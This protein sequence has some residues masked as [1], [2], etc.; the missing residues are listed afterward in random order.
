MSSEERDREPE[1]NREEGAEEPLEEPLEQPID[2]PGEE[3]PSVVAAPDEN[4]PPDGT[5]PDDVIDASEVEV[6]EE[7]GEPVAEEAAVEVSAEELEATRLE[8]DQYRDDMMYLR[9]EFDNV[10][11]RQ[12]R[13]MERVRLN[14]SES[15]VRELLPVLDNLERALEVEGDVR[16]GVKATLD[17]FAS[18]LGGEGLTPVPSDGHPFDPNIHEAVMSEHSEEHEENIVLKTFQRGYTLNGKPIRTAKVVVAR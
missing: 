15:L 9:A 8:R 2:V 7:S 3:D 10:R 16:E 18:V 12:E 6:V 5:E 17:Q 4:D 11:K 14:A 13:E 1:K